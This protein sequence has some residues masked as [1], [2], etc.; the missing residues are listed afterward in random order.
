[1]T[2]ILPSG[3]NRSPQGD[4]FER[5]EPSRR[6]VAALAP[7]RFYQRFI[8]PAFP[9]RCKYHPTCSAYAVEAIQRYGI[10]KGTVMAAW[11]ILR[12][13]P[14]SHGGYDPVPAAKT[15]PRIPTS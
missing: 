3:G 6:V 13:N 9:R 14:F 11:R 8:S 15:V 4:D 10:L 1:M 2:S 12:C 5:R 7:I